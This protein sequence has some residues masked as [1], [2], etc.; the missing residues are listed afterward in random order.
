MGTTLSCY[1]QVMTKKTRSLPKTYLKWTAAARRACLKVMAETGNKF[2]ACQGAG[3]SRRQLNFYIEKDEQFAAEFEEAKDAFI[4]KLEDH[5]LKR[6]TEG[7]TEPRMGP[8]GIMYDVRKF[9]SGLLQMLLKANWP[10]KYREHTKIDLNSNPEDI[11]FDKF[12]PE[13]REKLRLIIESELERQR[14]E[15]PK[16]DGQ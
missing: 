4:A 11:R 9:D 7:W 10:E 3:I 12:S 2:L 6:G 5:A 16:E 13:N 1:G 15:A 8:G 14:N